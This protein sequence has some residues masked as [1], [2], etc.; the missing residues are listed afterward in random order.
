[1][2]I[3]KVISEHKKNK[4]HGSQD[5]K[6]GTGPYHAKRGLAMCLVEI[7]GWKATRHVKIV[8]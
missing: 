7:N 6:K 1:M 2:K 8:K 4:R 3:I 5:C